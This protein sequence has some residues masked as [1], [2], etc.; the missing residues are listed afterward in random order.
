M[1]VLFPGS[2][3]PF[4]IGHADIVKTAL[5]MGIDEVVIG[6]GTNSEKTRM[7]SV[8]DTIEALKLYYGFD[9]RVSW[10][11]YP[12]LTA[13]IART[14]D[15]DAI[16]RGVRDGV[17][18]SYEQKIADI[19][20]EI[21]DIPTIIVMGDPKLRIVSSSFIREMIN[22]NIKSKNKISVSKYMLETYKYEDKLG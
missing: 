13:N 12:G 15:C 20:R 19:N 5:N 8:N 3:D 18:F 14:L 7:F 22:N 6:I 21:R 11:V 17:D 2:F 9:S 10:V 4:T 1:K 16:I